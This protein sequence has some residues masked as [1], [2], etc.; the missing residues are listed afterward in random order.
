MGELMISV[1]PQGLDLF[2]LGK[3]ATGPGQPNTG[4]RL[5]PGLSD[6]LL[7]EG[8]LGAQEML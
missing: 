7:S 1:T 8:S 3:R 6:E 5:G 2:M 4:A